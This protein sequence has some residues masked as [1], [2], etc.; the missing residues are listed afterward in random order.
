M[1]V[2]H[3]MAG[4]RVGGAEA[5]FERLLPALARAGLEQ[6][7]VIRRHAARAA[8]LEAAGVPVVELAFGQRLDFA[9]RPAL[10]REVRAFR[11]DLVLGWMSRAARLFP[12]GEIP[13]VARLGGYYDLKYY[14]G[15]DHLIGNTPDLVDD[16]LCRGWPR[17]RAHYLPNFVTAERMPPLER[18][19]LATPAGAP[20]LLGLG[21]LHR[22]KG[23]DLLLGA[24]QKLPD[25]WL[26]LAGEG[27]ETRRLGRLAAELSVASRAR[28]L[29]WRDDV[30]ALMAAAQ[31]VVAPS[32]RE[33][34]GNVVVE[35]W[36]QGRPVVAAA[37]VGPRALIDH[38]ETG[39][40]VP[41]E[42]RDALAE[43]VR[44]LLGDP[45]LA[46]RLAGGGAAAYEAE[47]TEQAVVQRYL[48]LFERLTGVPAPGTRSAA[49]SRE[50]L[51]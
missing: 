12:L 13:H 1:R 4:A 24:L 16:F 38:G 9:T 18:S 21:R 22:D 34:F 11:P 23:F 27:P 20:L 6:R 50:G 25:A 28:F 26:W 32:R 3:V 31:V 7:A 42:D 29:G 45:A 36:A 48:G 5:F 46:A 49:A 40:L 47:F 8:R 15:C 2:L 43:A 35:A 51:H 30:P 44:R 39:L 17:Q 14:R 19:E 33:P 37:A 41:L 10:R